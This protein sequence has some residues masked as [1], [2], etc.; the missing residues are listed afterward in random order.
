[1]RN[2]YVP[3]NPSTTAKLLLLEFDSGSDILFP[4]INASS[5]QFNYPIDC[6]CLVSGQPD[7]S[8]AT[9]YTDLECLMR[10]LPVPTV[11]A[12][13]AIS[14][15]INA[16]QGSYIKCYFPGFM[17]ASTISLRV[18]AKIVNKGINQAIH[19]DPTTPG[20]YGSLYRTTSPIKGFSARPALPLL[21]NPDIT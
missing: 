6:N 1:M 3:I 14:I 18:T 19:L 12:N 4:Y 17:V 5:T 8:G 2:S 7:F 10:Y 11:Y 20:T 9:T 15:D 21:G 16:P 13:T